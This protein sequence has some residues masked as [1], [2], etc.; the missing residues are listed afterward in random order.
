[1]AFLTIAEAIS[2][3][4]KS[5][6][7]YR[8]LIH[9]IRKGNDPAKRRLIK[10]SETEIQDARN[11]GEQYTYA[12]A[13]ELIDQELFHRK[14]E[15]GTQESSQAVPLQYHFQAI[16][17]HLE[18]RHQKELDRLQKLLNDEKTEKREMLH[19]AQE[20][21]KAFAT[22]A[23]KVAQVL[24]ALEAINKRGE[25]PIPG[26]ATQP[27]KKPPNSPKTPQPTPESKRQR[28]IWSQFKRYIY[29]SSR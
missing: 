2:K 3:Y 8:R 13:E 15:Q 9:D 17:D 6:S 11:R 29:G 20:D 16:I 28:G 22:V 1:M 14:S 12:I 5:Q 24:P 21:K 27:A 7:S 18:T 25:A 10:P 4:G 23:A 26:T 19:Y